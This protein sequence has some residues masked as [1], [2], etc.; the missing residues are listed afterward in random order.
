ML[1]VAVILQKSLK[2]T[3]F[4]PIFQKL[5]S[6][7]NFYILD[8]YL[9]HCHCS[10]RLMKYWPL[11]WSHS[12]PLFMPFPWLKHYYSSPSTVFSCLASYSFLPLFCHTDLLQCLECGMLFSTLR[13]WYMLF[14]FGIF[15]PFALLLRPLIVVWLFPSFFF[16]I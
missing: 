14:S 15:A 12:G 11:N 16:F 9:S 13:V 6:F 3:I 1:V 4:P 8:L 2:F 10:P 5:K 7:N